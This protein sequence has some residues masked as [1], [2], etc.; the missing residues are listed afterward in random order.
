MVITSNLDLA[1]FCRELMGRHWC[2]LDTEF[3]WTRTYLPRLGL[4][5]LGT[6]DRAVAVDMT[7]ITD[8]GPLRS[9]FSAPNLIKVV[10]AL[11]QDARI[12]SRECGVLPIPILDTQIG[13]GLLGLGEQIGYA[14]LIRHFLSIEVDKTEQFT[15][16]VSRPLRPEQ[17]AYALDDV[18]HLAETYPLMVDE[19]ERLGRLA[20]VLEDSAEAAVHSAAPDPVG[21]ALLQTVRGWGRLDPAAAYVLGELAQWREDVARRED[22]RPRRIIPDAV[23]LR[24]AGGRRVRDADLAGMWRSQARKVRSFL[25]EAARVAASARARIATGQA[26]LP[27]RHTVLR[28][29]PSEK[30]AFAVAWARLSKTSVRLGVPRSC[31]ATRT[32]VEA[33]VRSAGRGTREPES[34]LLR[35]WRRDEFGVA[36]YRELTRRLGA[37]VLPAV[38]TV[39]ADPGVEGRRDCSRGNRRTER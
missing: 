38:G 7:R 6:P 26:D 17:I 22:C 4:I 33:L 37:D 12:I 15:D 20:W 34:R 31:L 5:Q 36:V 39:A 3:T 13:A 8:P 2:A 28:M 1:S 16:W 32:E 10:H 27:E 19:L 24:V 18:R 21:A 11:D 9:V 23:L 25:P 30:K 14:A 29:S 35:G